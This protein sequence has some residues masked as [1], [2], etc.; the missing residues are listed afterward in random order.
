LRRLAPFVLAALVLAGQAHAATTQA[1]RLL[2]LRVDNGSTP[3]A[4][5][6]RYLTTV[7]P[8][9]DGFRDAAQVHF[10][11]SKPATVTMNVTR[12]VKVPHVVYTL[13]TML[14]AITR[15]RGSRRPRSIRAR[16]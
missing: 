12:T 6:S 16:T 5:D 9:G 11:L 1:P 10:T 15:F 4:G 7:S 14:A 13:T 2:N 3:F 8:N